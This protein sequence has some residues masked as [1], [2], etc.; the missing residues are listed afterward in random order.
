[1]DCKHCIKK[2]LDSLYAWT[3]L[4]ELDALDEVVDFGIKEVM[5][6]HQENLL[7]VLSSRQGLNYRLEVDQTIVYLDMRGQGRI[8]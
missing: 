2:K 7:D 1:M 4:A 8:N 6:E 5:G 3:N